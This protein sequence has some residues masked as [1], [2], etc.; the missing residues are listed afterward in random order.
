MRKELLIFGSPIIEQAEIEE[1]ISV[2]KSGWLGMGPRV[3]QFEKDFATYKGVNQAVAVNSCSA[4]LHLSLIAAGIGMG[5]EVITTPMTFCATINAII[6]AGA[7]PVLVDINPDTM[8]INPDLIEEKITPKTKAILPVHFAGRPCEMDK[9][10]NIANRHGL[11]VIEDCAHA[12]ESEYDGQKTGTFGDFGC[13]SFYVTKN[14]VTG[15]GGMVLA[16]NEEDAERINILRLHGISRDAWNRF[17]CEG[18][19][20]YEVKEAGFKYNMTD[21]QAAIGIHQLKRVDAYWGRRKEIWQQYN[22]AFAALPIG[23]PAEPDNKTR[24]AYHLYTV[25]IDHNKA[26]MRRN[27]FV[28]S[29]NRHNVGIGIHY[30]SVAE[31]PYYKD[32]YSWRSEDYPNAMAI[33][34]QIVSIPLSAKMTD[35]NISSVIEAVKKILY[36]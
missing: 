11:K 29:M 14:L 5:D 1:V 25:I 19:E 17:S 7:I 4:A 23:L 13:F 34:H 18:Y 27:E 30:I 35:E 26:G 15:E 31:H 9:I 24:H 6:H 3:A 12:I 28:K 10:M 16:K 36:Q 33:G 2:M 32:S 22:E 8:N 20:H 21:I